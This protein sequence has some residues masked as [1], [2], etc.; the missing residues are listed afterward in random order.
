MREVSRATSASEQTRS[1]LFSAFVVCVQPDPYN[2]LAQLEDLI[3]KLRQRCVLSSL[4]ISAAF[5][6]PG[7]LV[8]QTHRASE[9]SPLTGERKGASPFPGVRNYDKLPMSF[10]PN[11]G[12]TSPDVSFLARGNGYEL[13]LTTNGAV[14]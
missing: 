13:F 11:V 9:P 7:T 14:L 1:R 8:G 6:T 10:E 5:L 2:E 12:Q 3:M 4:L